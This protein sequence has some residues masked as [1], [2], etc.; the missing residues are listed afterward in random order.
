MAAMLEQSD[1][2][3]KTIM[4]NTLRVLVDKVELM[5]NVSRETEA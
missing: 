2:E 3:F 5:G 4:I 1:Q